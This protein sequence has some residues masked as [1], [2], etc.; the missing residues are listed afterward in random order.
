MYLHFFGK[1]FD[2]P[3]HFKTLCNGLLM[4]KKLSLSPLSFAAA[5]Y[6]EFQPKKYFCG[7]WFLKPRNITP[8]FFSSIETRSRTWILCLAGIYSSLAFPFPSLTS[9]D[10]KW[11]LHSHNWKAL[12]LMLLNTVCRERDLISYC[13]CGLP[14]DI[15]L[16]NVGNKTL[17]FTG[18]SFDPIITLH[19]MEMLIKVPWGQGIHFFNLV[20]W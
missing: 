16:A 9:C 12:L 11:K 1:S 6:L 4:S 7:A 8:T 10:F 14:T 19:I 13:A 15:Q 3:S 20:T 18:L 5:R 17:H 2:S